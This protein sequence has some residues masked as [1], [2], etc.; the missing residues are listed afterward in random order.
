MLT[1]SVNG[2]LSLQASFGITDVIQINGA[3]ILPETETETDTD[4]NNLTQNPIGICVG[5][6]L[7][8]E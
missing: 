6:C 8:G 7:C 3:F 5:V 1:L 4:T 2:P